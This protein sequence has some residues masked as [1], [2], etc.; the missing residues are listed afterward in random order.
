MQIQGEKRLR[1]TEQ[2]GWWAHMAQE[3]SPCLAVVEAV[4]GCG[5][6]EVQLR[7]WSRSVFWFGKKVWGNLAYLSLIK[8]D[9][10]PSSAKSKPKYMKYV[11]AYKVIWV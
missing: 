2:E 11:Y 10:S 3:E 4:R 9:T 6:T 1:K 7:D 8:E 5:H